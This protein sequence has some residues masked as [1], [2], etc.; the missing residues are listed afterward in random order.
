MAGRGEMTS[1]VIR[2]AEAV[3]DAGGRALLVGGW[4]R[5]ELLGLPPKDA[6]LEVFG[7]RADRLRAM[8]ERLGRVE[9]VGESFAVFKVIADVVRDRESQTRIR[10]DAVD[11]SLPRRESK[12]GRGHKGFQV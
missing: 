6:D 2:I 1:E 5:D 10:Q 11:V 8:L 9:T 12:T 3:R 7:I 4:V